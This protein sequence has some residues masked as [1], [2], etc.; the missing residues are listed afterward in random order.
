V[1]VRHPDSRR[2]PG[3][4]GPRPDSRFGSDDDSG[5]TLVEIMVVMLVLAILLAIAIPT[6][7]GVTGGANDR[8]TQSNLNTALTTAKVY[9]ERNGQSYG[10]GGGGTA[11]TVSQLA[12]NEAS[13]SWVSGTTTTPG[14]I[15]V[16]VSTDGNGVILASPSKNANQC[17]YVVDNLAYVS[18]NATTNG[19]Y[20]DTT[21]SPGVAG[22]A[23]SAP[24]K[25]GTFYGVARG[26]C[27]ASNTTFPTGTGNT[28]VWGSTFGA[29]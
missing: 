5:F 25:A 18:G 27:N 26:T 19:G 12:S 22:T 13:L 20:T 11:L 2:T 10:S 4:S 17:W 1:P 29:A 3:Q 24:T 28:P 8:G 16:W 7:I 14:A 6:F 9:A 23:T 15:S 21:A